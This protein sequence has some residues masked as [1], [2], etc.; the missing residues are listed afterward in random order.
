MN[1]GRRMINE[2]LGE[3]SLRY[4]YDA[5]LPEERRLVRAAWGARAIITDTSV[6][7]ILGDRQSTF[8]PARDVAELLARLNHGV[9]TRWI[10]LATTLLA[11]GEMSR[12]EAGEFVLVADRDVTVKANTKASDGYLYVCAYLA[13]H[14]ETS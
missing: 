12:N 6:I 8:G 10:D 13:P 9:N 7:D 2:E 5:G 3:R 11:T 4:G 14:A 1:V